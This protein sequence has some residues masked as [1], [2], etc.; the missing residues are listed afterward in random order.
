M[1]Q[2]L[3]GRHPGH[4]GVAR[5]VVEELSRVAVGDTRRELLQSH[6]RQ[7][8]GDGRWLRCLPA[9]HLRH[10]RPL[11]RDR[12]KRAAHDHVVA[13]DDGVA[14][15][16]RGPPARPLAPGLIGEHAVDR[17]EVIGQ[18]VLCQ[19]V[20]EQRAADG[21]GQGRRIGIPLHLDV[22]VGAPLP[23][24]ERVREPLLRRRQVTVEEAGED[25]S[26]LTCQGSVVHV[27]K[28]Y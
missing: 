27:G 25:R 13:D 2:V 22:E 17:L 6:V 19:Q 7:A 20:D 10:A 23:G 16:L 14:H 1:V 8:V 11:E 5:R 3:V 12:I 9:R 28:A 21:T 24:D 18:V 26:K 15:L 4:D